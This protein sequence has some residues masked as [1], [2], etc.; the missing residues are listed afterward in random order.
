M[1][2]PP[3]SWADRKIPDIVVQ[4]WLQAG[5]Q[6]EVGAREGSPEPPEHFE[7]SVPGG[8]CSW[9]AT[10]IYMGVHVGHEAP[11]ALVTHNTGLGPG[12][13]YGGAGW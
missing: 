7:A 8:P 4:R 2:P 12:S 1:Y 3:Q 13:S 10:H 11:R 5:N 9:R 6:Q